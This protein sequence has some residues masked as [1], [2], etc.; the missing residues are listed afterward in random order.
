MSHTE[1]DSD[2]T[3]VLSGKLRLSFERFPDG[4][5]WHAWEARKDDGWHLLP[6]PAL[7][8]T[9]RRFRTPEHA[10]EFFWL[11]AELLFD[12]ATAQGVGDPPS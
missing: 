9:R 12:T 10:K 7:E 3:C 1:P 5:G 11:L 4:W 8:N 2:R 6:T